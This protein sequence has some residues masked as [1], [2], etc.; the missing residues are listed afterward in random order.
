MLRKLCAEKVAVSGRRDRA[1]LK[2]LFSDEATVEVLRFIGN[3]E[4]GKKLAEDKNSDDTWD[5]ERSDRSAD[6]GEVTL[7]GG[8][9]QGGGSDVTAAGK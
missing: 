6:E 2:I 1:D 7:E 9:E 4:V 8:G 5:I 3:T